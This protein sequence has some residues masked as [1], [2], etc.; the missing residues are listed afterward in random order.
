[1]GKFDGLKITNADKDEIENGKWTTY[2]GVELKIAMYNNPR[3]LSC[4]VEAFKKKMPFDKAVILAM[5]EG[6]LVDWNGFDITVDG[7]KASVPY[8]NENALELLQEDPMCRD[9][10]M[11][12]C[13]ANSNYINDGAVE[14][15]KK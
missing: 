8:S 14:L 6:I 15:K 11:D 10:I 1:M 9:H 4:L 3:Y 12:F 7:V 13:K 5:S 2:L